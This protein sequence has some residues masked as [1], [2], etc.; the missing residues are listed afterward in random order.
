MTSASYL[1]MTTRRFLVTGLIVLGVPA[2]PFFIERA[3]L[4]RI[5]PPHVYIL[6]EQPK[7]LTEEVAVARARE[8]LTR[9]GF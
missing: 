7:L 8:T 4:S 5:G 6:S 3:R 2:V 9:D 1:G